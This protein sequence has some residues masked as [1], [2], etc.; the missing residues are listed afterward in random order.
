MTKP[1]LALAKKMNI[2]A[3]VI[4]ILVIGLAGAMRNPH[5][6]I[7]TDIDFSFLPPL[8]AALNTLASVCLLL[9]FYFIK[10]KNVA[11]HRK[12][13]YAAL[14]FSALFLLSYVTYHFTTPETLYCKQ[15]FIRKV[16]FTFL[17]SHIVLAA[18]I[19]PFILFT[20]IRAYTGQVEKH[21][22]MARWVFP[23]WLYVAV[24][25]PVVYFMLRPCYG[26]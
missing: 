2:A 6:K 8:H 11:A 12:A 7:P 4:S 3:V 20:F 13:I 17:I 26:G 21:R 9:A 19:F 23:I 25:G 1:N 22:Q 5:W 10:N 18:V 16:Y 14:F 15:G 24:T